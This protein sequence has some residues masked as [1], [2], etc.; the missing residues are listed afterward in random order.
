MATIPRAASMAQLDQND[1][2]AAMQENLNVEYSVQHEPYSKTVRGYLAE[3]GLIDAAKISAKDVAVA[4][5]AIPNN[6]LATAAGGGIEKK[7][8][9]EKGRGG[10]FW[11]WLT[12]QGLDPA[13]GCD[14][15][16]SL[17]KLIDQR[18]DGVLHADVRNRISDISAPNKVFEKRPALSIHLLAIFGCRSKGDFEDFIQ[19]N[20]CTNDMPTKLFG[21][22]ACGDQCKACKTSA[23]PV[24]ADCSNVKY[25]FGNPRRVRQRI[26]ERLIHM[27]AIG[28]ITGLD[29]VKADPLPCGVAASP[30]AT[31]RLG[32]TPT[33]RNISSS[34]LG[35]FGSHS[36]SLSYACSQGERC[37]HLLL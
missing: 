30:I 19:A 15:L 21:M 17:Q 26:D 4:M 31:G 1:L 2:I 34:L 37:R 14:A 5:A 29:K 25:I 35:L 32:G 13:V 18:Q 16:H 3:A 9:G 20:L 27:M 6:D 23:V 8:P 12:G 28:A 10:I 24:M 11:S 36:D 7:E 33:V 22:R